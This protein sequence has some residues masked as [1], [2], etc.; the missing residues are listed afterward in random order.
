MKNLILI[1]SFALTGILF[2]NDNALTINQIL[3]TP[4]TYNGKSV[5]VKG[6]YVSEFE[7]S[8]LWN[9]KKESKSN[10]FK[11]SI[12][13]DGIPKSAELLDLEGNKV[14]FW[15]FRNKYVEVTGILKS[16]IDTVGDWVLGH[17]HM[18]IWLAE[19]Q[20]IKKVKEITKPNKK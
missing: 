15:Y 9:T 11:K 3:S 13:I 7:N 19:I 10:E 16:E 6:Y 18:N 20:K 2:Q 5:T 17:G 1:V 8:S 14:E 12:W 4:E